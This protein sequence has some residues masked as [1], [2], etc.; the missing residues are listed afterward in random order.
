MLALQGSVDL[1]HALDGASTVTD[2]SGARLTS[3]AEETE[4][5]LALAGVYRQGHFSLAAEA[6]MN[7]SNPGDVRGAVGL[8]LSAQF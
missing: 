2:V 3:E 4:L 7:G 6:S 1:A 5:R 8:R